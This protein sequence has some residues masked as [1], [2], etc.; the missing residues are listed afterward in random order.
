M[1]EPLVYLNGQFLP[2]S[3]AALTLH[4]AGFIFGATVTD[5][6]R[7]FRRKP[8]RLTDHVRRFRQ[9]CGL[10]RVP[11]PVSD[12]ELVAI[13]ERL[14]EHNA[15]L[16]SRE[17]RVPLRDD[18]GRVLGWFVPETAPSEELALVMFATPGPIGYYLGQPGGPGDGPPTLGLH[19]FPLPLDRYR[20]LFTEGARLVVPDT[21]HVSMA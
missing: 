4:D 9:S 8:Y 10:C 15:G 14:I 19:T 18:T 5:L 17:S 7:T 1:S 2:Q 20:K 3:R 11:Q 21:R 16:L 6:C 12:A 13:A